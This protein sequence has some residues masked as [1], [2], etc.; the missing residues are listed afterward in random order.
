MHKDIE[1]KSA[2]DKRSARCALDPPSQNQVKAQ[3][4]LLIITKPYTVCAQS[5]L[6]SLALSSASLNTFFHK[7]N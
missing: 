4:Q 2:E 5:L 6:Q 7:A 1:P 3:S